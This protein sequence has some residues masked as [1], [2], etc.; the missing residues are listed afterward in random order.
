[1][2][3][4][5]VADERSGRP[6]AWACQRM[7]LPS[8]LFREEEEI[9]TG[10]I[11][12]W[13]E[14][15]FLY[16]SPHV[17]SVYFAYCNQLCSRGTQDHSAANVLQPLLWKHSWLCHLQSSWACSIKAWRLQLPAWPSVSLHIMLVANQASHACFVTLPVVLLGLGLDDL[18]PLPT[19][20]IQWSYGSMILF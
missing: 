18:R 20:A 4:V 17:L 11:P 15:T 7:E 12:C 14:L 13:W 3:F 1:M 6:Q 2:H 10:S 8:T 9:Q 19:Q 5:P 16:T